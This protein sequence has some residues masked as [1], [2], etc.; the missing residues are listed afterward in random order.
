M[1]QAP[2]DEVLEF[3]VFPEAG[4]RYLLPNLLDIAAQRAFIAGLETALSEFNRQEAPPEVAAHLETVASFEDGEKAAV[5]PSKAA[6]QR[7]ADAVREWETGR[8]L[9][10]E[11]LEIE[12]G[13][14]YARL[15]RLEAPAPE[16]ADSEREVYVLRKF[17]WKE[18][19]AIEDEFTDLDLEANKREVRQ[20]KRNMALLKKVLAGRR[21]NGQVVP[22][23]PEEDLD[24]GTAGV[25]ISRMWAKNQLGPDLI[26]FFRGGGRADR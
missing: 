23:D 21:E 19:Q 4:T 17:T 25:L 2:Y 1:P 11:A 3:L 5:R 8:V 18:Q 16:G 15:E 20:V 24:A 26:G 13:A 7:A 14:A 9:R 6:Y 12:V 10:R 22:V